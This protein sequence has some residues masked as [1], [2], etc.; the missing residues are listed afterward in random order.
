MTQN[1]NSGPVSQGNASF[2]IGM[3]GSVIVPAIGGTPLAIPTRAIVVTVAGNLGVEF[4]DGSGNGGFLVPVTAGQ[5]FNWAVV[6]HIAG[7]TATVLGL[8]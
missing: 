6:R 3:Q 2:D 7:N 4:E 8:R 1:T 5:Q